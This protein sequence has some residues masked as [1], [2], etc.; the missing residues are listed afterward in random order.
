MAL[1]E[2]RASALEDVRVPVK[3]RLSALGAA[4]MFLYAYGDVFAFSARASSRS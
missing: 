3:L 2:T 1:I 4:L